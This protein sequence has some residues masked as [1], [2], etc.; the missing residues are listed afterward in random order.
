MHERAAVKVGV[1][2]GADEVILHG[3]GVED[4][5]GRERRVEKGTAVEPGTAPSPPPSNREREECRRSGG[6]S[7]RR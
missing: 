4:L 3:D 7:R 6:R 2:E 5:R 1:E